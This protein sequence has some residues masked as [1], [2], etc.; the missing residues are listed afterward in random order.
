MSLETHKQRVLDYV[1]AFNAFDMD[2]L[3]ALFVPDPQIFGV[4]GFGSWDVVEPIWRELHFGLEMRLEVVAMAAEADKVAA[5]LRETGR[6]I[7]PFRGMLGQAP[8]GLP[9]EIVAME[10][11]EFEGGRIARRWG[12]RDSAAI[13]RQIA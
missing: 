12:A 9:Y 1:E 7:G 8:T 4:L 2:R 13:M 10:W 3:R 5:R 6:F 11:F